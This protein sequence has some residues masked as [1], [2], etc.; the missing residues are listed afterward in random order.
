[1]SN[2]N[3]LYIKKSEFC[4][5]GCR[6]RRQHYPGVHKLEWQRS[7]SSLQRSATGRSLCI[8]ILIFTLRLHETWFLK[9]SYAIHFIRTLQMVG[10]GAKTE[11]FVNWGLFVFSWSIIKECHSLG[12]LFRREWSTKEHIF[13]AGRK[14]SQEKNPPPNTKLS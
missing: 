12:V 11:N 6:C 9:P 7:I 8:F 14:Y 5:W 10:L 2:L 13:W 3:F 1:M 4:N